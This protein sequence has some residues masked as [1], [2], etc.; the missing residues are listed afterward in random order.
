M[1]KEEIQKES[2]ELEEK[3]DNELNE[4]AN[5]EKGD[6]NKTSEE[7][8]PEKEDYIK[9]LKKEISDMKKQLSDMA[10]LMIERGA[11]I[12][13][14]KVDVTVPTSLAD[15]IEE[16]DNSNYVPIEDLDLLLK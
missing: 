9:S 7:P 12:K 5:M 11:V 14:D 2:E 4:F 3:K 6:V 15:D 8:K 16:D 1:K 13:E 10:D